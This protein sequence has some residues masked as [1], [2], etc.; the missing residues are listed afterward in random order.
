MIRL[1]LTMFVCW[2]AD[3]FLNAVYAQ[4]FC[5]IAMFVFFAIHINVVFLFKN[6]FLFSGHTHKRQLS[7]G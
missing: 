3:A 4:L 6:V 2:D 7:Y 5:L 1:G